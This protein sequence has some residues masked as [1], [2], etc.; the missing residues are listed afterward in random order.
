MQAVSTEAGMRAL[1]EQLRA[2]P[3]RGLSALS[4]EQLHDL[5]EA[6]RAARRRESQALQEAGDR[7][8]ARIPRLLRGPIRKVVG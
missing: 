7:A 8:L 1:E 4:D 6:I 2:G 3:P 5:A